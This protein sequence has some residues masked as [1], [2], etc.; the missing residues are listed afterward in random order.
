[1]EG[2]EV[3]AKVFYRVGMVA[4]VVIVSLVERMVS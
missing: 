4:F 1:L 3:V 2:I